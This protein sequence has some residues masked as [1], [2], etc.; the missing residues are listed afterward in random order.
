MKHDRARS[1]LIERIESAIRSGPEFDIETTIEALALTLATTSFVQAKRPY[2]KIGIQYL[3]NRI[4]RTLEQDH[5]D[6]DKL[7]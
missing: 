3:T 4:L 6:F 2:S 1:N 7:K 5:A